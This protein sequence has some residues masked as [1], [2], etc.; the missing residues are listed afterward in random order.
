MSFK[1]INNITGWLVFTIALMVYLM[2]ME[3]TVS[4]WDC[5]EF[6]SCAYKLQVGHSPGAPLFMLLGRI[7]AVFAP[8]VQ[9]VA[10]FVNA[11]SAFASA[12]TV[13]FLFWSITHFAKR[14]FYKN[15][16]TL[17][18]GNLLAIMG[19]GVVGALAYTFSDTFWFS[20]VEGEVYATSSFFTAVVF[21]AIL[22][23][24]ESN[25]IYAD[26]WLILIAYLIG[27]SIGVHLLSLLVIPTIALVYY[28]KR[29]K[30]TLSG[31]LLAY[32]IGGV[33]LLIV[34]YG[35]IQYLPIFASKFELLFVNS[36]GLP[37]NSGAIFFLVLFAAIMA[38]V[39]WF[40][41]RKKKY[42][43][44]LS[45]LSM[46]FMTIGYMCYV[47]TMIRANA[48]VSINM[49]NPSNVMTL[50]PYLQRT[51]YGSQPFLTGQYYNTKPVDIK[52]TGE[53][54]LPVKVDGKD[55][56][57][58]VS[59]NFDYV[60]EES[61]FFPRIW[62]SN[63]ENG[64]VSFYQNWLGLADGEEPT[65][66]DNFRFFM[67]YQ[68]NHMFWRYFMWNYTGRQNDYQGMGNEP[69]NGNWISGING[70]DQALG[71]G[72]FNKMPEAYK[73][74]KAHNT[75]YFLP[76]IVGIIGLIYQ[77]R[78]NKLDAYVVLSLFFFTGIA[79][80]LYINNSPNQPR[81][82]DYQYIATYAYAIWIGFGVLMLREWLGK[83]VKNGS[84]S[85]VLATLI[86]L[87]S[88]PA[89]MA[90]Q[91]WDDH[92]RSNKTLALDHARN[93]LATCDKNAIL[94]TNG[95]NETYP[96]WYIQE[97]EGFR[98]DVRI[99]NYNLLG[100][101]WQNLQMFNKVNEA[102]AVPVI[103]NQEYVG[104][105]GNDNA[106]QINE[107]PRVA[108]K[109]INFAEVM[110]FMMDPNNAGTMNSGRKSSFVPART[111]YI[112]VNKQ[113]VLASGLVS[114]KDSNVSI[115]DSIVINIRGGQLIRP[116]MS[117]MNMIAGIAKD[118]WKRPLYVCNGVIGGGSV[119]GLENYLRKEGVLLKFVPNNVPPA[120][121]GFTPVDNLDKSLNIF[122]KV[123]S[124]GNANTNKVYYDESN[125]RTFYGY[126]NDAASLAIQLALANRTEDA[127]KVLDKS[128]A[129][130]S[131]SSF[132]TEI[133]FYEQ[134]AVMFTQAY[135]TAGA[136]KKAEAVANK[137]IK[138]ANDFTNYY[139]GLPESKQVVVTNIAF[140]NLEVMRNLVGMAQ[141]S[142]QDA[143]AKKWTDAM[144]DMNKRLEG[145]SEPFKAYMQQMMQQMQQRQQQGAPQ[146]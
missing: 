7:F 98:P 142:K 26:R 3:P 12:F 37:F 100:T 119:T 132:P 118:G 17:A 86:G 130:I 131:E 36:F 136:P 68:I 55:R 71:R 123:Y 16:E 11:L 5:G 125:R 22:K 78:K 1:K 35:V 113:A 10:M 97:V 70:I 53:N 29:Y 4:F 137:I 31:G 121:G 46:V 67:G 63:Q 129:Q 115:P 20:A 111:I 144:M 43:L 23:W 69:N 61:H 30:P 112:P 65:A 82:R 114:A 103:W 108:G 93:M 140:R 94:I 54:Y 145:G 19:A 39:I 74:N 127:Q 122:T 38:T 96:L 73:H 64:H 8:T 84:S 79:V 50:I 143:M 14:V 52:V 99:F 80:Q 21:W 126:R 89:L 77:F 60:Y 90:A 27:L 109:A 101:D 134:T 6:I 146:S 102:A 76:F 107:D 117:L 9:Q 56:Y 83:V 95:D 81:E 85:A 25:D 42:L 18:Q 33:V 66:G 58:A 104:G 116:D 15:D 13:L 105:L 135:L 138:Y 92:D 32:F 106:Y 48:G 87:V 24:E 62:S 139:I 120:P 128:L 28:F 49:T 57:D 59:E 72:D 124:F 47:P 44:H 88:V 91:E 2:T 110:Q 75:L 141:M 133:S 34:Q 45:A 41:K 40:A 51:Q